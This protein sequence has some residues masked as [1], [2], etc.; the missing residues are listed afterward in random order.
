MTYMPEQT[1]DR[2]TAHTKRR[3]F[4]WFTIALGLPTIAVTLVWSRS[5]LPS[6]E[7]R[8]AAIEAARAIPDSENAAILYERLLNDPRADSL[9]YRPE[10]LDDDSDGLTSLHAWSGTDYPKLA[11]WMKEHQWLIDE[12]LKISQFEKCRFPVNIDPYTSV[13]VDRMIMVRKLA[14]F[15]RRAA[16]GDVGENRVDDAIA[17]WRCMVRL[18]DHHYQQPTSSDTLI[19]ITLEQLSLVGLVAFLVD[20]EA[21]ATQLNK[22]ESLP[23][24]TRDDW[25]AVLKRIRSV[26]DLAEKRIKEELSLIDRLRFRLYLGKIVGMGDPQH[27]ELHLLYGRVL[28]L[29][30]G[31]QILIALRRHRNGQGRWPDSLDE[32]RSEVPAEMFVDPITKG[33]FVYKPT[34]AGFKLYSKGKNSFD[35]DGQWDNDSET[36]PDDWPI[37]PPRGYKRPGEAAKDQ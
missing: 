16:N 33:E 8:L 25:T 4:A 27:E 30:R 20:G 17:K 9:D 14:F 3:R 6:I 19:G 10:F 15:L 28:A 35:E 5:R 21:D 2:S 34:D 29:R 32:I 26:E 22:I 1:Q 12:L 36:G 11:A 37:W 13:P 31:T 23:L 18:A 7:E 24:H